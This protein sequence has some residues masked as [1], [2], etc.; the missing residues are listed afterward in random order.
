MFAKPDS[1]NIR[2]V[3]DGGMFQPLQS[4]RS[5]PVYLG[6]NGVAMSI[7]MQAIETRGPK[8]R[9][10]AL[11]DIPLWVIARRAAAGLLMRSC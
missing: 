11:Q 8:I 6:R 10:I 3:R 1:G 4:G 2:R 7:G 5:T 9:D